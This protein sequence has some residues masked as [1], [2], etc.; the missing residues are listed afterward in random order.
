MQMPYSRR[1]NS[2][3]SCPIASLLATLLIVSKTLIAMKHSSLSQTNHLIFIII[4]HTPRSLGARSFAGQTGREQL[5][6]LRFGHSQLR[7]GLP[8][9]RGNA[10]HHR[11]RHEA[12]DGEVPGGHLPRELAECRRGHHTGSLIMC[13][14]TLRFLSILVDHKKCY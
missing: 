12:D 7:F 5:A 6:T 13:Y 1:A 14:R 8:L 3:Y 2:S 11:L 10:A 9:Q 4:F